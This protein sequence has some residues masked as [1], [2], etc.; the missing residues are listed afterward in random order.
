MEE[1]ICPKCKSKINVWKEKLVTCY[2]CK[3]R[4][5]LATINGKRRLYDVTP[6]GEIK[7]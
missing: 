4:L 5:L 6:E 7:E 3:S 1:H 2:E